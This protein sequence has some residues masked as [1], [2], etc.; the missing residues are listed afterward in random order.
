[1]VFDALKLILFPGLMAYAASSDLLT[2][3]IPN[4]ISIALCAGF[5]V[6]ALA[7]GMDGGAT[8][9]HIAAGLIVLGIAFFMFACGWIGGGDAKLAAAT[10][11]WMGFPNLLEYLI[12]AGL[13]GGILTLV[14]LQFRMLPLPATAARQHWV[15][16]LHSHDSGVP[17]GIALA[18][19]ALIVYPH[20]VWMVT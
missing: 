16:R 2:M 19:S 5:L 4:R 11:L 7:S 20:T 13:F 6:L 3:T 18:A 8:M 10:A 15:L 9:M 17:Y 14:L 12:Y 1:M